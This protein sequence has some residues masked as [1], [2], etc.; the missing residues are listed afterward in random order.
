MTTLSL[1]LPAARP[2]LGLIA[3][4]LGGIAWNLFGAV[5]FI[6][7]V[8]ATRESLAAGGLTPEQALVVTSYPAWMTAAFG[9]GVLGGFGALDQSVD[10]GSMTGEALWLARVLIALLPEEP[11]PKGLLALMLYCSAR[12][13]ARRDADGAFTPLTIQDPRLW[14]RT[15][16]IEAE[17]LLTQAAGT[18]RFGRYQCEAAIQSVHIQRPYTGQT[19]YAA[20]Q[21]LYDLLVTH[22]DSIGARIGRAVVI[23]EAGD[24]AGGLA[25]LEAIAPKRIAAHQPWW[26]AR[27]RIAELAGQTRAAKDALDKALS[28]TSDPAIAKFLQRKMSNLSA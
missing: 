4:A 20:L 26:V 6:G 19:N 10:P 12:H 16:I 11:E 14:D 21:T 8:T 22:S 9:V 3:T 2:P 5:Q 24:P 27:A 28:L 7:S 18:A 1:S 25:A 23:A 13:A 17:A 15:Q